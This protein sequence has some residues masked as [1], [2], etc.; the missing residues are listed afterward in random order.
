[1]AGVVGGDHDR[2]QSVGEG[3]VDVGGVLGAPG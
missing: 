2:D 3:F 1:V